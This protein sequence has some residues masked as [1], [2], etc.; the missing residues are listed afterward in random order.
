MGTQWDTSSAG[1]ASPWSRRPEHSCGNLPYR[2]P[3]RHDRKQTVIGETTALKGDK[4]TSTLNELPSESSRCRR[5]ESSFYLVNVSEVEK[6]AH[7]HI[8]NAFGVPI[9]CECQNA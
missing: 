8:I 4:T 1:E 5:H 7:L 9:I 6:R 3:Q 2:P